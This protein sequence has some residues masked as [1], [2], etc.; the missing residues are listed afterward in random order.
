MAAAFMDLDRLIVP[1]D[2]CF[3]GILGL[4][5]LLLSVVVVVAED[6][7]LIGVFFSLKCAWLLQ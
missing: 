3:L 1:L 7:I 4:L 6:G 2:F 5:L